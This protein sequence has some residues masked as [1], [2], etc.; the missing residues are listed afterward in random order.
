QISAGRIEA[1]TEDEYRKRLDAEIAEGRRKEAI[2]YCI[3]ALDSGLQVRYYQDRLKELEAA[4]LEV[5][6]Q[7]ARPTLR[8]DLASFSLAEVLQSFYMSKRSG[9]LRIIE[10]NREREIYFQDG[11][12][13]LL[14]DGFES[15]EANVQ[16]LNLG[17]DEISETLAAQ[18]KDELYEVF[19]WEAE[20]E[21]QAQVLPRAFYIEIGRT[22]RVKINT[23]QFL[24]EAVRRIAEWEEVRATLPSD[25]LVLTFES[26]EKK[27]GA[28]T[29]RGSADLLLLVDGRHR[30]SDAIRM[31]GAGRFQAL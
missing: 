19:L 9:T 31:S 23:Q 26:Y 3:A 13:Y 29:A 16:P 30:I 25:D 11:E 1:L 8:G 18:M 22:F 4:E 28:I 7:T 27:M 14:I 24:M 21:F 12:V 10:K 20:F 15:G 6:N 2:A 5:E 17:S